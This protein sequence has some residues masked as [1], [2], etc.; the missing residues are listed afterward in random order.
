MISFLPFQIVSDRINR[1]KC[2]IIRRIIENSDL[3]RRDDKGRTLLYE[4]INQDY[5]SHILLDIINAGIDIASRDLNGA[6]ARDYAKQC[7]K[8]AYVRIL[9]DY[10][11]SLAV[12][13]NMNKLERLYLNAYDHVY[14][15][16]DEN[17]V[18]IQELAPKS[19]ALFESLPE[20]K[21]RQMILYSSTNIRFCLSPTHIVLNESYDF[22]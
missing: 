1:P 9:D 4:V 7:G 6:T 21:V 15:I 19:A 18:P 16:S 5:P 3:S 20:I 22:I 2:K 11:I 12:A 13:G 10:V 14:D 8:N 17:G